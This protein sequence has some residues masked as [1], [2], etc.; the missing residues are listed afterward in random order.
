MAAALT[1][2]AHIHEYPP[3]ETHHQHHHVPWVL[4][5]PILTPA[6]AFGELLH[7]DTFALR[8]MS[9]FGRGLVAAVDGP[10]AFCLKDAVALHEQMYMIIKDTPQP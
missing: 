9:K 3:L 2:S 1:L 5:Q 6:R 10:N 4:P 7:P 8:A